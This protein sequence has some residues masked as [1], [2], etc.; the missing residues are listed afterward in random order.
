MHTYP[1]LCHFICSF[2]FKSYIQSPFKNTI[3][4]PL[5]EFFQSFFFFPATCIYN[6]VLLFTSLCLFYLFSLIIPSSTEI[7]SP[8]S[9]L[10]CSQ[11]YSTSFFTILA[12]SQI[13][14]SIVSSQNT[15]FSNLLH[16]F[17]NFSMKL[18]SSFPSKSFVKILLHHLFT[19]IH[20]KYLWNWISTYNFGTY[21]GAVCNRLFC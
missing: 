14:L 9:G 17:S 18:L 11:V 8:S 10:Y 7:P 4:V 15:V 12:I 3:F 6:K 5:S 21:K 20:T 2:F 1:L 13:H 19:Y 16:W